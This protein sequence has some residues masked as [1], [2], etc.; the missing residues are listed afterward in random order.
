MIVGRVK[1][2]AQDLGLLQRFGVLGRHVRFEDGARRGHARVPV[3]QAL[4]IEIGV[5]ADIRGVRRV[6]EID[7]VICGGVPALDSDLVQTV[8]ALG[9]HEVILEDVN[10]FEQHVIAVRQYVLPVVVGRCVNRSA[11]QLKV[12]GIAVGRDVE[13]VA[14]VAASVLQVALAR[15]NDLPRALGGVGIEE[16]PLA[17]HGGVASNH[18]VGFA[19]GFA[20]SAREGFIGFFIHQ[21][22][23]GGIGAQ[24]VLVDAV[25]TQGNRVLLGVENRA[26]VVG[27]RG[28]SADVGDAVV[29]DFPG[30]QILELQGVFSAAN[31]VHAK[32]K[33]VVVG[34]YRASTNG[35]VAVP[36]RHFIDVEHDF[37]FGIEAALLAAVDWVFLAF[38]IPGVVVVSVVQQRNALVV[39][40]DAANDFFKEGFLECLGWL[41]HFCFVVVLGVEVIDDSGG[42]CVRNLRFFLCVAEAHPEVIILD[43]EAVDFGDV[44]LFLGYRG[45]GKLGFIEFGLGRIV[46]VGIR[47]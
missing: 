3:A 21:F 35:E 41:Q 37:F 19:L 39:L 25:R 12:L 30:G 14:V 23:C 27:P 6:G 33:Q 16:P 29:E 2:A 47:S 34:A 5:G 18:E 43:L 45:S 11:D 1:F 22:V 20:D 36:F 31:G 24:N 10:A 4:G 46:H 17:A 44:L 15:L 13:V 32:R 26:V 38:L 9:D 8:G 40:L 7:V 28:A 42:L